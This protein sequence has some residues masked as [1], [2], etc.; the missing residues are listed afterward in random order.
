MKKRLLGGFIV[1]FLLLI[2][3]LL[4]KE[5]FR[6]VMTIT[7]ILGLKELIDIKYK[8]KKILPI[9]IISYILL[10]ILMLNNLL[11]KLNITSII[12]LVLL[13]LI[14]PVIIY[15]DKEKYNVNDSMYFI[16]IVL[17]LGISFSSISNMRDIN[18][19]K[20]IYIFIISFITDTY[21]FIGGSLIGKHRFTS[22]SPKKTIEGCL[23]GILVGT[24]IGSMYYISLIGSISNIKI[25]V[26]SFILTIISEVGDLIFSAIKRYFD[27][28][29]Y[30]NIIP[31][32]GGILDRFDSVI[33]VSL[34]MSLLLS[35]L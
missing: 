12:I 35:I 25:I 20:C 19:Y 34:G 29:D 33:F 16:G 32:H 8:K 21:A 17:L 1:V 3:L 11:Y 5:I 10:S 30:S 13:V 7:S 22:I 2:S 26:M 6:I 15:N 24:F 18:I 23:T 4:G 9:K 31:G 28:K 14:L 27:K